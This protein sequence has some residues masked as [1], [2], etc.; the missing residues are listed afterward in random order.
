MTLLI[1]SDPQTSVLTLSILQLPELP[2]CVQ[3]AEQD[4]VIISIL[5]GCDIVRMMEGGGHTT[6]VTTRQ[7]GLI[8]NNDR[9]LPSRPCPAP[10]PVSV[11]QC[12][13]L[14]DWLGWLGLEVY[15][16][17]FQSAGYDLATVSRVSP[18]DLT[19]VGIQLPGHRQ[20]IMSAIASLEISDGLPDFVP[21]S[22][23]EW[24]RLIRLENYTTSLQAQGYSTVHQVLRVCV[25]DLED[26][27]FYKLGHQKRLMLAIKK[28]KDLLQN[29]SR[30]R[31]GLATTS[32]R[33]GRERRE[34]R[35]SLS[36]F[37]RPPEV[38]DEA[39][40][41]MP[42]PM[43]PLNNLL[44]M[45]SLAPYIDSLA[46]P[47]SHSL[48]P[49]SRP[50]AKVSATSRI[51]SSVDLQE[52][53]RTLSFSKIPDSSRQCEELIKPRL[54][55]EQD[56]AVDNNTTSQRTRSVTTFLAQRKLV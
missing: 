37:Q 11:S 12:A 34:R 13:R 43:E 41:R 24:L 8:T 40:V 22:L 36:T 2:Q 47:P 25:E 6:P 4:V 55:L 56:V 48:P 21:G 31:H 5:T 51:P 54:S 7:I 20:R 26:I 30:Y 19:A 42:Q 44:Y 23:T 52:P 27:G 32:P 38:E 1:I 17:L 29:E 50:V 28:V 45:N 15:T 16:P 3:V 33:L 18:E 46:L 9:H 35:D 49:R 10:T 39:P 53:F 14:A